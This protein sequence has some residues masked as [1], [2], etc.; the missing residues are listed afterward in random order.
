MKVTASPVKEG[1]KFEETEVV[2][3]V[4]AFVVIV[5]DHGGVFD[6][7]KEPVVRF[8]CSSMA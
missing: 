8:P 6:P 5:R 1:F 4:A 3:S 7:P 2:V